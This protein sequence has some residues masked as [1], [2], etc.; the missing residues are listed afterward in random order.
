MVSV[1]KLYIVVRADLPPGAQI[2]QAGHAVAAFARRARGPFEAWVDGSNNL[3]VLSIADEAAL[4]SLARA[5][6]RIGRP[7]AVHEPDIGDQLTAIAFE[8]T[9]DAGRHVSSLPLALRRHGIILE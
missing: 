8:G 7:V 9:D 1:K 4:G 2:A 3:V 5:L 6:E